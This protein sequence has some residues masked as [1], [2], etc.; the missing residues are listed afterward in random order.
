MSLLSGAGKII[1]SI[2]EAG[3]GG[4][5]TE[6]I[7]SFCPECGSVHTGVCTRCSNRRSADLL[8]SGIADIKNADEKTYI[9]AETRGYIKASKEFDAEFEKIVLE[10]AEAKRLFEQTIKEKDDYSEKLISQH[11]RLVATRK[12]LEYEIEQKAIALARNN[13]TSAVSVKNALSGDSICPTFGH[14]LISIMHKYR[15]KRVQEAEYAGFLRAKKEYERKISALKR[16]LEKL[17]V[18]S[19]LKIK[20]LQ[21]LITDVLAAICDERTKIAT[22]KSFD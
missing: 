15:E 7:A 2:L 11:E 16:D 22:I 9:D 4:M 17:R 6:G 18:D 13:G 1:L 14:D 19:N 20:E 12:R 5:Q 21:E 10:Y 3:K 8:K